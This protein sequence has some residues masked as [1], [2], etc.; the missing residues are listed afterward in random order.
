MLYNV[1]G[2]YTFTNSFHH[3]YIKRSAPHLTPSGHTSDQVIEALEADNHPFMIG[4]QWHPECMY[5]TS[6]EMR[7]LFARFIQAAAKQV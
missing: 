3:Q 1:F 4:V 7:N 2:N 5:D 6:P